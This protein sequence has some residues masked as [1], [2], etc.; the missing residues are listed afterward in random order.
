ML[1]SFTLQDLQAGAVCWPSLPCVSGWCCAYR[2]PGQLW[3]ESSDEHAAASRCSSSAR[4]SQ[5]MPRAFFPLSCAS[6]AVHW[7]L[8]RKRAHYPSDVL[9]GGALGAAVALAAWKLWPPRGSGS[10]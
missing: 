5:E 3:P 8:V 10:K 1:S 6:L 2:W 9:A 4:S 7:T